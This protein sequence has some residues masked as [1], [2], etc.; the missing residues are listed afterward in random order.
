MKKAILVG[1]FQPMHIGHLKVIK[2]VLKEYDKV[3]IVIGSSQ[4]SFTEKNPF[5][6]EERKKMIQNTLRS[7]KI[8]KNKYKIIDIP[9]VYD[10]KK[11]VENIL[12]K[13][14]FDVVL[15]K[16]VWTKRCFTEAKIPVKPH[17]M[18]G[19]V[20]VSKIRKMIKNNEKWEKYVPKEVENIMKKINLKERLG[21]FVFGRFH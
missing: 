10:D 6:F 18:F 3:I 14:K 7:E 16:N 12:K 11:W 2:W 15:T 1:R 19:S 17:P 4:D 21:F 8:K 9:D 20:S 5:T 13:A